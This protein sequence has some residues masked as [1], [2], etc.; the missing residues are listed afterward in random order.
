VRSPEID[1]K[2]RRATREL[3]KTVYDPPVAELSWKLHELLGRE[4]RYYSYGRFA[5]TAAL[6]CA[7]VGPG[8]AVLFPG[9]ICRDALYAVNSLG[10]RPLYY[11]VSD[12][13]GLGCDPGDLPKAKAAVF[14]DYFGFPQDVRPFRKYAARTGAW[15][16]ED[17]AHGLFSLDDKG[18]WLGLRGDMGIFSIRKTVALPNGAALVSSGG[19]PLPEALSHTQ[20]PR[21]WLSLKRGLRRSVGAL[22]V[23]PLRA[24]VRSRRKV[25]KLLRREEF[26]DSGPLSE[27]SFSESPNPC[28]ELSRPVT[29]ADPRHEIVRRRELYRFCEGIVTV[30]G[31][32]PVFPGMPEGVSPY[33]YPF[34]AEGTILDKVR[35]ALNRAGLDT[36]PWPDLPGAV[37]PQAPRHYKSIWCVVFL[38]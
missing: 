23:R 31:G 21:T 20:A 10:G 33:V 16:I 3:V 22:G 13:L 27:S 35:A 2:S 38:W 11:P 36:Y 25:K 7:G 4:V 37:A 9:L 30:N 12:T 1:L 29:L 15:L 8:D 32:R 19:P 17:N 18:V 6:K 5:L 24:V 14:V 28:E 26:P 34:F